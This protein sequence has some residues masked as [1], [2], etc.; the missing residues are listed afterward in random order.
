MYQG[1]FFVA[2]FSVEQWEESPG[3]ARWV[4]CGVRSAVER[5][6]RVVARRKSVSS[7]EVEPERIS[8]RQAGYFIPG[9]KELLQLF[10]PV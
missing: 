2:V 9:K 7:A 6:C 8:R 4:A 1:R 10:P 5:I 3:S